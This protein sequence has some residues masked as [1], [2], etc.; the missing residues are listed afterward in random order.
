MHPTLFQI[1]TFKVASFGA[2]MVVAFFVALA[3]SRAR[4]KRYSVTPEQVSDVAF[5]VILFGILGARL[6]FIL[7]ELP[8][9]LKNPK[10][11][12]TLQFQGLTSFGG[13]ILGGIAAVVICR[14]KKISVPA[15]MDIIGP[16]FVVGSAIGRVGCLL[17]GCCHGINDSH[18]FPF[19][20]FSTESKTLCAPA[21]LYDTT[22]CLVGIV[23]L[24]S[25]ERAKVANG[26][27]RLGQPFGWSLIV[28]GLS[29]FVY[30]FFRAGASSSTIAGSSFTEGH[31][32]AI[33]VACFGAFVALRSKPFPA[34]NMPAEM[35]S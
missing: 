21:Q 17:N 32:I 2:A 28:Y 19:S 34:S 27:L 24:L 1:G 12:L 31:I 26:T 15:F 29:R 16:A 22:M 23:V 35:S 11:L 4:A 9:Y 20:V 25:I 5:W 8:E 6:A 3:I 18:A 7:Q 10:S 33:A 14:K 13:L 30:E